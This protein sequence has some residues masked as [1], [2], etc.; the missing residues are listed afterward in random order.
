MAR[1]PEALLTP[2]H[3]FAILSGAA[4]VASLL[5]PEAEPT[6]ALSA[7]MRGPFF[8]HAVA[9]LLGILALQVGEAEVGYGAYPPLRR[10]ARLGGQPALG[11]GI[12][13]PFL[14]LHRAEAALPW[15]EWG[16]AVGFLLLYGLL[17]SVVGYGTGVVVHWPGL[18]FAVKYGIY[19]AAVLPP[20]SP[21]SPFPALGGLW[22]GLTGWRFVLYGAVDLG[23]LGA[24]TW[25]RRRS[26]KR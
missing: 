20:A 5:W 12:V 1:L 7:F 24:W 13:L 10:A 2:Y 25:T 22:E 18:R 6:A 14:L 3:G 26:S 15:P 17:W 23:V 21:L 8:L 4:L 11:L 9:F 16:R 19:L